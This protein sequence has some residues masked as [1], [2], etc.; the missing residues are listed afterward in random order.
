[1][2]DMH[3]H[4]E[5]IPFTLACVLFNDSLARFNLSKAR[6]PGFKIF[7]SCVWHEATDV[8]VGDPFRILQAL[9]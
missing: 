9:G 8:D 5:D 2:R 1:M 4:S 7:I 3:G 6:S